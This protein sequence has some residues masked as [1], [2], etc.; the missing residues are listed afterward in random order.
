MNGTPCLSLWERWLSE[1]KAERAHKVEKPSPSPAVTAPPKGEPRGC[2]R[3]LFSTVYL[4]RGRRPSTGICPSPLQL[5]VDFAILM[6]N[7][8]GVYSMGGFFSLDSKFMQVMSRVA[9]LIILNVIYLVT[10]LPVVTIG[11]AMG[12]ATDELKAQADYVTDTNENDGVAKAI[13]HFMG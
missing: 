9:D 11:V 5:S 7:E 6:A 2:L 1:A 13:R 12:N 3:S 4:R 10:C 8:K